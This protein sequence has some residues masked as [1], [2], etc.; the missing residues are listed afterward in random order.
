MVGRWLETVILTGEYVTVL[1][2]NITWINITFSNIKFNLW[3][4]H[5]NT[6]YLPCQFTLWDNFCSYWL[7]KYCF[8]K[9]TFFLHI[10]RTN[11]IVNFIHN[12]FYDFFL[13]QLKCNFF[14][15]TRTPFLMCKKNSK[16]NFYNRENKFLMN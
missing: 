12:V 5:P 11:E 13:Q 6:V 3:Q 7:P 8:T 16:V 9:K 2:R 15:L 10:L 4:C 14:F 1:F